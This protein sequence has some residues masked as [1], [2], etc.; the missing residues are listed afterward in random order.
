MTRTIDFRYHVVRNGANYCELH[1]QKGAEPKIL[2]DDSSAI[3]TKLSG[4]FLFPEED[5]NWLTDEIRPVMIIDGVEH[6]LGVFLPANVSETDTDTARR[7]SID[8]YDRGWVVK[9]HRTEHTIFFQAGTNYL[10]A[11]GS[12]LA[13][14]GI[15]LISMIPTDETLAEDR[16]DWDIGTSSLDIVNQLL[17][18]I[19]YEELWF[20]QD[21]MA[22]LEPKTTPTANNVKHILDEESVESLMIPGIRKDTDFHSAPNVFIC[23]CSN[24]DKDSAMVAIAENTNPQSPLSTAR[25]GRRISALVQVDNIASQAELQSYADRMV[26]DSLLK[27]EVLNVTTCLMPGY[28]VGDTAALRYGEISSICKVKRWSMDL[29]VGGRMAITLERVVL[30]LD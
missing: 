19:N 20:D 4:S 1:A 12:V 29:Q 13:E 6:H 18:E 14:C 25:R 2:M 22:I 11:V 21:G 17:S 26:T 8:S 30:N 15:T 23:V 7:V 9:D 10:T 3:K 24:A 28:G 27:G 5:V 16:A